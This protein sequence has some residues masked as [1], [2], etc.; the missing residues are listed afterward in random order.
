MRLP[1]DRNH[2]EIKHDAEG[3]NVTPE[4]D[5]NTRERERQRERETERERENSKVY[6]TRIVV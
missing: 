4:G 5:S 6:F 1:E 2:T 3:S